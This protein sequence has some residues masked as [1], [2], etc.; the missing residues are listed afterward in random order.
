[1]QLLHVDLS[2]SLHTHTF[3]KVVSPCIDLKSLLV[4][5]TDLDSDPA[6]MEVRWQAAKSAFN[7]MM[8]SWVGVNALA[9]SDSALPML[10]RMLKDVKVL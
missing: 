7:I 9:S 4:S 5:F 6:E 10:I 3:R 2:R 8:R 1:M